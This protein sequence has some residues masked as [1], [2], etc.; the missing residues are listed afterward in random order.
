MLLYFEVEV[1]TFD[2]IKLKLINDFRITQ[3]ELVIVSLSIFI[4]FGYFKKDAIKQL[5]LAV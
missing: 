3:R 1:I 4:I 5:K 2:H